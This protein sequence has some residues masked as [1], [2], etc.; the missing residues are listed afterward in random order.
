MMKGRLMKRIAVV[1]A[2][3]FAIVMAVLLAGCS[4]TSTTS[5]SVLQ[6]AENE[7]MLAGY[8]A[9]TLA[10]SLGSLGTEVTMPLGF[11]SGK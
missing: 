4:S 6:A 10:G 11:V 8:Q 2:I 3:L 1:Y 7:V 9:G 5:P